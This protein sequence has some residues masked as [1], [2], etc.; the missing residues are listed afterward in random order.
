ML[1]PSYSFI[2]A[3]LGVLAHLKVFIKG[4]WHLHTPHVIATH[5]FIIALGDL[6]HATLTAQ[7]ITSSFSPSLVLFSSYLMG[8]FGSI[9]VYRIFFHRLRHFPGPR[10]AGLSKLWHVYQCRDS[11]NHLVLDALHKQYGTFVRTGKQ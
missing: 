3:T 7:S 2:A 4:E 8:L 6:L 10:L 11:R 1:S 9:A 5:F